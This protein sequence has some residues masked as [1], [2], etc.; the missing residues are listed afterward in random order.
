[1]RSQSWSLTPALTR[2]AAIGQQDLF[3]EINAVNSIRIQNQFYSNDLIETLKFSDRSTVDLSTI[4]VVTHGDENANTIHTGI[5]VGGSIN[6][7]YYGYGGNDNLSG[8]DGDDILYG[9]DGDET[10]DG[11]DGNDILHGGAARMSGMTC[12]SPAK[13]SIPCTI[14]RG[15]GRA[16]DY[17]R[18]DDQRHLAQ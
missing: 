7:I 17:G 15:Y 6:D 13:A 16:L 5:S 3:I 4:Q 18:C 2:Y 12:S 10:V 14:H 11:G 9:G 1:M 8:D